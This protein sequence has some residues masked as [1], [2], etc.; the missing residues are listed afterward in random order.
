MIKRNYFLLGYIIL[1]SMFLFSSCSS[2]RQFNLVRKPEN[3]K[4]RKS[5]SKTLLEEKAIQKLY[6]IET[7]LAERGFYVDENGHVKILEPTLNLSDG[8]NNLKLRLDIDTEGLKPDKSL[9]IF[10]YFF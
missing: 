6:S 4:I 7:K 5:F 2:L 10:E 3:V 1:S 8:E 9:L